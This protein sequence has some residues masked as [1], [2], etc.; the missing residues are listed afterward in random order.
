[1]TTINS[2]REFYNK[3]INHQRYCDAIDKVGL[4]NSERI[5]F[6]KYVKKSD[7]ILDLGCGTGRTTINLYKLGYQNIIGLDISD[8]LID[9]AKSYA[10]EN[11][12]NIDFL[13]DDAT[14]IKH[15]EKGFDVIFFSFNGIMSIPKKENR[16]KVLKNAYKLLKPNGIFIFT[17][18]NRDDSADE[19]KQFWIDEKIKWDNNLQSKDLY[20]FGDVI[21]PDVTGEIMY[22]HIPNIKEIE[23][24]ANKYNFKILES[25]KRSEIAE[26]SIEVKEFSKETV[27]WVWQKDNDKIV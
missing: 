19:Y 7:R 4:W 8:K 5:I 6:E 12:L 2:V 9:S 26:E 14:D 17:A 18:H 16:E 13:V 3:D 25:T 20:D 24:L 1:M 11:N 21:V 15:Q 23:D 10:Q 27:F 22:Y